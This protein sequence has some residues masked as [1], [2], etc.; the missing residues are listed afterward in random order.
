MLHGHYIVITRP[1]EQAESLADEL[2]ARGA[3]PVL[4]PGL[5]FAPLSDSAALDD[6]LREAAN[7]VYDM[8][9]LTSGQAARV[10]SER[11]ASLSLSLAGKNI[12]VVGAHTAA[13]CHFEANIHIPAMAQDAKT[14]L[15]ALPDL[16]GNR[17]FLPQ[18][19]LAAPTLSEGLMAQGAEVKIVHAYSVIAGAG[20]DNVP[21]LI[22]R[23]LISAFT[24]FSGSAVEGMLV[25]LEV[26]ELSIDDVKNIP[27]VCFGKITAV[28][29][30]ALGLDVWE[31]D[32]TY[33]T[34]YRLLETACAEDKRLH[35]GDLTPGPS[36]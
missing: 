7:G 21:D 28:K 1:I 9:I 8:L 3:I 25:R 26:A 18:S 23:G 27:S 10:V 20:G 15:A 32:T 24:F 31:G 6:A 13:A 19:P 4:Y 2:H 22:R 5:T 12:W 35:K 29:G 33:T 17:I 11:V 36:P 30:R 14:L 34:F 16:H